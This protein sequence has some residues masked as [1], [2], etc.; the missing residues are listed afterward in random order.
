MEHISIGVKDVFYII[1]YVTTIVAIFIAFRSKLNS[2]EKDLMHLQKILLGDRGVL[3]VVDQKTC[4]ENRDYVFS[5][6]RR[7]ENI[8]EMLLNKVDDLNK[9]VLVIMIH[10][11]I[12]SAEP[13]QESDSTKVC[14]PK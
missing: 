12:N 6:I 9:N 11:N 5:A 13:K 8:S 1:T 7:S 14:V 3:N 4:K 2:T 10:M